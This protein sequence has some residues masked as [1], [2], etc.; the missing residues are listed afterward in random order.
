MMKNL[1][2]S[3]QIFPAWI[4]LALLAV[5]PAQAS[6]VYTSLP[7]GTVYNVT[8]LG[9]E[10]TA[11]VEFGQGVSIAGSAVLSQAQ[12]LLSNWAL[13]STYEPVG[14]STGF[15]VPLTLNLYQVGAGNSV[16][17]LITTDTIDAHIVWRPEANA[18]CGKGWLSPGGCYNG[19][20][21]IV[22]FDLG[23]VTVPDAFIWGLSFDT[24]HYGA[25]P[26]GV[27]GPYD[28]LNVGLSSGASEGSDLAPN[29][30]FWNTGNGS[31]YQL[32]G[33]GGTFRLDQ[34][35]W[36]GYDPAAEFDAAAPE[37]MSL[38]LVGAGLVGLALAGRKAS[39]VRQIITGAVT[40][41][42]PGSG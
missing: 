6:L 42:L 32:G 10:A 15:D 40:E 31:L 23:N 33:A 29:S 19:I 5:A 20:A 30:A 8:S 28:S 21:Q 9:Y 34:G 26:T 37:P 11:T 7:G 27:P 36:A 35:G 2:S 39:G 25:S 24:T 17:D 14:T 12:I 13:E 18:A 3:W 4:G 41:S 22:T 38:L 1:S 16:G